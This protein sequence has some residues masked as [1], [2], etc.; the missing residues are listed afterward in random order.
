M[1]ILSK[2]FLIFPFHEEPSNPCSKGMISNV[3]ILESLF[4]KIKQN[5]ANFLEKLDLFD[6]IL[7]GLVHLDPLEGVS[8]DGDEQNH[9]D[10]QHE[11]CCTHKCESLADTKS[12]SVSVT[13]SDQKGKSESLDGI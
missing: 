11:R 1:S 13:H 5:G 12:S 2:S 8:D 7:D 4:L 10:D 6:C 3:L 9:H